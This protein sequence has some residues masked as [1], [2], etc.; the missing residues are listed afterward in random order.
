MAKR[1]QHLLVFL[2]R[3]E[4]HTGLLLL[5]SLAALLMVLIFV[6]SLQLLDTRFPLDEKTTQARNLGFTRIIVADLL[7]HRLGYLRGER[8]LAVIA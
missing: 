6:R 3:S 5:L 7:L 4:R 8:R 2:R 1:R